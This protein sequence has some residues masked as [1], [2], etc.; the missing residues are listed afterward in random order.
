MKFEAAAI[1]VQSSALRITNY[2]SLIVPLVVKFRDFLS[3]K[4][5]S[6]SPVTFC[7]TY[8]YF[9]LKDSDK[10]LIPAQREQIPVDSLTLWDLFIPFNSWH[11][12]TTCFCILVRIEEL[13]QY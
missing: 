4:W 11:N 13:T 12:L 5:G 3:T 7:H 6:C 9:H 8:F 2:K 1:T 10:I